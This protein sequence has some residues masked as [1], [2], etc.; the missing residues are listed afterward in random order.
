MYKELEG[1][2]VLIHDVFDV[3]LRISPK[4]FGYS[5]NSHTD[6]RLVKRRGDPQPNVNIIS[7]NGLSRYVHPEDENFIFAGT[8]RA[9]LVWIEEK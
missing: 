8:V 6:V 1:K 9:P 4:G 2:R 3:F 7:T 5:I